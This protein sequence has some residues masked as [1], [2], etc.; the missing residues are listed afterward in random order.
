MDKPHSVTRRFMEGF[1]P[2]TLRHCLRHSFNNVAFEHTVIHFAGEKLM[3]VKVA[4]TFAFTKEK[5]KFS[6][7][8]TQIKYLFLVHIFCNIAKLF[9]DTERL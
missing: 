8:V 1:R 9:D 2:D 7:I 6:N 5:K 3:S 4:T